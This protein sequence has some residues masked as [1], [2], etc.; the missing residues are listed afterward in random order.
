MDNKKAC[1]AL[2][3]LCEFCKNNKC[4][5]CPFSQSVWDDIW[6]DIGEPLYTCRLTDS[7]PM[8]WELILSKAEIKE[9]LK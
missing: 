4:I 5:N 8:D 7:S 1:E 9:M 3:T 6:G 2:K